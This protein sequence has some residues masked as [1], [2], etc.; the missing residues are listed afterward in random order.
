M[1]AYVETILQVLKRRQLEEYLVWSLALL[2]ILILTQ[3]VRCGTTLVR[4]SL[5]MHSLEQINAPP[6]RKPE[7]GPEEKY[8]IILKKGILGRAPQGGGEPGLRVF[9]ILGESALL[10][11]SPDSIKF[12]EVG[13]EVSGGEKLVSI[14]TDSVILEKEGEQ[15][16]LK[17]FPDQASGGPPKDEPPSPEADKKAGDQRGTTDKPARAEPPSPSPN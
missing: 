5:L 14:G 1:R 6:P 11:S 13:A 7:P 2:V 4:T 12:D 3:G 10:G 15:R 17:V 8:E 9:G 16:T